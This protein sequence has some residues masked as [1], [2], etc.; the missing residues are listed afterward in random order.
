MITISLRTAVII[1]SM[2][3]DEVMLQE[4]VCSVRDLLHF[5]GSKVNFDII[6]PISG[7]LCDDFEIVI[8]GQEVLFLH[9]GLDT[10]LNNGDAVIMNIIGLGG[11]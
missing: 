7:D 9:N 10:N 6:D 1:P 5:I 4:D 3:R 8:N 2:E 11:G